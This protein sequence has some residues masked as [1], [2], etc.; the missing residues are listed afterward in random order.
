MERRGKTDVTASGYTLTTT[1]YVITV[2]TAAEFVVVPREITVTFKNGAS[3]TYGATV[4]L[5][6][7]SVYETAKTN[8][9]DSGVLFDEAQTVFTLSALK[10][11]IEASNRSD[12][13][14]CLSGEQVAANGNYTVVFANNGVCNYKITN[15]SMTGATVTSGH[16]SG[17][18]DGTAY[19]LFKDN[20]V[21][22]VND[23]IINAKW[24]FKRSRRGRRRLD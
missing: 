14:L 3:S 10:D 6:Q 21:N 19:P 20:N 17:V 23:D 2:N 15:A 13:G 9:V 18:Y 7:N 22:L 11:S 12:I 4:N 1:N 24:W 16:E 5:Y 8:G